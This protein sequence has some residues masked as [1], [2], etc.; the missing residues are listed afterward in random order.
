MTAT[1]LAPANHFE[2]DLDPEKWDL[3]QSF[4]AHPEAGGL[5]TDNT[6]R[7]PLVA[8]TDAA[9][10]AAFEVARHQRETLFVVV[11]RQKGTYGAA[12]SEPVG[13][14]GAGDEDDAGVD[15]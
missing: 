6:F 5:K 2:I 4:R 15:E 7:L 13:V 14:A 12:G 3:L 8:S 9:I 1:D 11:F 10:N